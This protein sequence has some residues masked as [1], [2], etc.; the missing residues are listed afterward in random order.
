MECGEDAFD[1]SSGLDR[2]QDGLA[3]G[4]PLAT[5]ASEFCNPF[6]GDAA[7]GIAWDF[8]AF[9]DRAERRCW[10]A[11]LITFGSGGVTGTDSDAICAVGNGLLSLD[12]IV[13]ADS[14]DLIRAQGLPGVIGSHVVLTDMGSSCAST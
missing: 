7:D 11:R 5:Q 2:S 12:E 14:Q 6:G 13:A 4:D 1:F 9:K 10:Q 8:D 3:D